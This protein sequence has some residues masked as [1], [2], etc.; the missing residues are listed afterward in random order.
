MDLSCPKVEETTFALAYL[1][2]TPVGCSAIRPLS[3]ENIKLKRFYI[4]SIYRKKSI[5]TK[6]LKFLEKEAKGSGFKTILLETGNEQPEAINL[7]RKN[8]YN[9]IATF[10]EYVDCENSVCFVKKIG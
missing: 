2:K 10:G 4:D 7:Y 3:L 9:E 6:L 1:G 5:A 8:G